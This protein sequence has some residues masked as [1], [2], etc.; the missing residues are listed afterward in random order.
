[1]NSDMLIQLYRKVCEC[2]SQVCKMDSEIYNCPSKGSPPRGFYT[3]PTTFKK[4]LIVGK[5]PGHAL[6]SEADS[7][8][9]LQGEDLVKA[10]W[11]FSMKT[12]FNINIFSSEELPS[13]RFHS[14]LISY[15]S[16]IIGCN[17]KEIFK[18]AAYTNLVKCSTL[19]EQAILSK[20]TMNECFDNHLLKE[21][22]F[23]NPTLIFALGRETET[24]LKSKLNLL[25][26]KIEIA[27]IKH[28]S[29]FY[30]KNIRNEKLRELK[31]S[32]LRHFSH[33]LTTYEGH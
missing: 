5:N 11:A 27:Y 24:Y 4:V 3:E 31:E 9:N 32:Y 14:N 30:N 8:I 16:E 29:Y 22:E 15:L 13:T 20:K 1:M 17:S 25:N 26:L 6:K 12:F 33:Q 21:I 18:Y 10:H 23:F 7:Y 2:N 28:P 19:N